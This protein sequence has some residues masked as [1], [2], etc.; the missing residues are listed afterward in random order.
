MAI[1]DTG[2]PSILFLSDVSDTSWPSA[3]A[4][5]FPDHRVVTGLEDADPASTV[6]G[7]VWKH[8]YGSL[9][10][11]RN[12]RILINLG[13]GV[14]H[15][16]GDPHLP[17]NVPIVRLVDQGLTARMSEYVLMHCLALHRRDPELRAA[18]AERRWN[19]IVPLPTSA[20]RV[21]ILGFGKLGQACG[22]QLSNLGF[23]VIG[24]RRTQADVGRF[25]VRYGRNGLYDF[26]SLADIVVV[27]LPSTLET[28]NLLDR[29]F[30]SEMRCGAALINVGR[31]DLIVDTD[32]L[33]AL[34]DGH[35]RHAVLDVFRTEPL[36]AS[37]PFW[38]HPGVT[39]TP[40]NSAATNPATA[41]EQVSENLRRA[42]AG[43]PLLH[44]IDPAVG[45]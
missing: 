18:Q 26:L 1:S 7:L 15:I 32:L 14:D 16:V 42:F 2:T 3:L 33:A 21:G 45:Y 11:Y 30:F 17:A 23:N 4:S 27:L 37:H 28:R 25:D 44:R 6:A 9:S 19:F 20:T 22:E 13:A 31:G 43:E 8:P 24:W 34:D 5:A 29:N 38:T 10:A 36:P 40:H 12:M 35:L 39:I 41:L